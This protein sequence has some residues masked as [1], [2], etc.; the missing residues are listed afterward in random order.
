[1]ADRKTAQPRRKERKEAAAEAPK[2]KKEVAMQVAVGAVD[3]GQPL[4]NGEAEAGA[5]NGEAVEPMELP[6]FEIIT[7]YVPTHTTST[8]SS[9]EFRADHH[10][11]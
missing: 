10:G 1:M 5:A 9:L 3:G 7:G 6:P 4:G 11:I 8:N 2:D